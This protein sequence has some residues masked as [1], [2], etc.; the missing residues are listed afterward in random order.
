M[1][2]NEATLC[3]PL[4]MLIGMDVIG[5]GD[6]AVTNHRGVTVCTFRVPSI[7]RMDFVKNMPGGPVPLSAIQEAMPTYGDKPSRHN[8]RAN[9]KRR[10]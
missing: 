6:F 5:L 2:V 1:V 3:D 8:R 9:D 7:E 10:R 4:E